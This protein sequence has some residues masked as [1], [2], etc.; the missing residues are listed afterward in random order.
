M[1]DDKIDKIIDGM[2][3]DDDENAGEA[4]NVL[5]IDE[6]E[7]GMMKNE[8]QNNESEASSLSANKWTVP[9]LLNAHR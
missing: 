3:F 1:K 8:V 4:L 2:V 5:N 9:L 7:A 6:L